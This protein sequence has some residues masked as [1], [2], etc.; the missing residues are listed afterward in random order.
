M[1]GPGGLGIFHQKMGPFLYEFWYDF[2]SKL[3]ECDRKLCDFV[4]YRSEGLRRPNGVFFPGCARKKGVRDREKSFFFF[5]FA[6]FFV[7]ET[8]VPDIKALRS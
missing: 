5:L 7:R 6:L 8:S 1:G 3:Y 2:D 4:H